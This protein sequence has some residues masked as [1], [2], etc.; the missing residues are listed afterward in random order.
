MYVASA[1]SHLGDGGVEVLELQ[2]ADFAAVHRVGPL[3]AETLHVELVRA[4]TYLLVGIESYADGAVLD[5]GMFLKISHGAD[6]LCDAGLVVGAKQCG[7]VGH[8]QILTFIAEQF[9]KLFGR[10]YDIL[11]GIQHYCRAVVVAHYPRLHVQATHV[12]RCVEVGDKTDSR[13]M[14]ALNIAGEGSHE[15]AVI[16]ESDV[17]EVHSLQ[18]VAQMACKHHLPGRGRRHVGELVALRIVLDI[19]KK[20]VYEGHFL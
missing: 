3:G 20:S 13:H 5:L 8:D 16:V 9:G 6:Y 15:V 18:L 17:L 7:A 2:L 1:E 11:F 19:V 12:G 14:L 4:L 10:Q